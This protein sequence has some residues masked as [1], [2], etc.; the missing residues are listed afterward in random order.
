MSSTKSVIDN[1]KSTEIIQLFNM[2]RGQFKPP[3]YPESPLISFPDGPWESLL[4]DRFLSTFTEICEH[5][6]LIVPERKASAATNEVLIEAA[7]LSKKDQENLFREFLLDTF[8]SV[9]MSRAAFTRFMIRLG[10][11]A[12]EAQN[13]FRSADIYNRSSLS[14]R[15][16]LY[17]IAALEPMTSHVGAAAEIRCRYIYRFFSKR[18]GD[19][20]DFEDFTKLIEALQKCKNQ[21]ATAAVVSQEADKIIKYEQKLLSLKNYE[22]EIW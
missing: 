6:L 7:S 12:D 17:I 5:H 8:P 13:L 4:E 10:W 19:G 14:F 15:D 18:Q 16:F 2:A 3:S 1:L 11:N 22:L 20:M 9:Y 21:N